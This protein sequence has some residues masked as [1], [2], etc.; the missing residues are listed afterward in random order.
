MNNK[1]KEV[2]SRIKASWDSMNIES[3]NEIQVLVSELSKEGLK[4]NLDQMSKGLELYKDEKLGFILFAY[5]ELKGTYRIPHNH[6]NGWVVYAVVDGVVEM[7]NYINWVRPDD[8]SDLVLKNS[9]IIKKGDAKIYYPGD[10]H[11]TRCLSEN[12]IILRLTSCDLKVEE[13]EGRM[14]RFKSRGCYI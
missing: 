11:D 7:G 6:G 2:V 5:S 1:I 9:E 4:E 14:V 13:S 8:L 3:L 10:I 12:A